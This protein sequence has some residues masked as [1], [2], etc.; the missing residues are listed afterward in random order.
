LQGGY[1]PTWEILTETAAVP[2]AEAAVAEAVD[3]TEALEETLADR[4]KCIKLSVLN[5]DKN[6]KFHS[7]L[8]K[9]SQFIAEIVIIRKIQDDSNY[10]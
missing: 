6:V 3:L 10:Y 2:E 5:A 9:E 8:Q 1:V 7:N 4:E